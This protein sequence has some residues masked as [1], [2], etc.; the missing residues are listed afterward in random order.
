MTILRRLRHLLLQVRMGTSALISALNALPWDEEEGADSSDSEDE[1]SAARGGRQAG[2]SKP[3]RPKGD[4][5]TPVL[6][7]DFR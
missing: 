3:T 7:H 5:H 1:L 2:T 6:T 4:T